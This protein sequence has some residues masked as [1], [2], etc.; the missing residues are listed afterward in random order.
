MCENEIGA[1]D[2]KIC[3]EN[4]NGF[5][6]FHKAALEIMLESP[7]LALTYDVGHDHGLGGADGELVFK[8]TDKLRHIHLHDAIG[9]NHHL[10]LG[11][12]EINI[13]HYI[14]VAK[15]NNCRTVIETK[16]IESLKQSIGWLNINNKIGT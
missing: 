9:K 10:A 7:V 12:G 5:K 11:S 14:D 1:S 8:N 13:N 6:S 2:I 16:T 3:I 15:N 4:C